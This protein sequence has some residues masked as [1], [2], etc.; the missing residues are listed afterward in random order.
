MTK[1]SIFSFFLLILSFSACKNESKPTENNTVTSPAASTTETVSSASN[2]VF[3]HKE[4][5]RRQIDGNGKDGIAAGY[6]VKYP[7]VKTGNAALTASVKKWVSEFVSA[8]AGFSG[9]VDPETGYAPFVA[10]AREASRNDKNLKFWELDIKDNIIYNTLKIS[11][12][13]MDA[14]SLYSGTV[15]NKASGLSSF[16]PETGALLSLD[17]LTTDQPALLALCEKYYRIEKADAIKNGLTFKKDSPFK[18]PKN[19]AI[20]PNGVLFHYNANEV[21]AQ[22]IGEAEFTIP[23]TELEKIMDLK[24]YL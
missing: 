13:R 20:T 9:V 19:F 21:A 15:P 23:F 4:I 3:E 7:S 14:L 6:M 17:K 2:V 22:A 11:S 16:D 12:I 24:K 5:S 8:Q 1:T 10:M 18:L